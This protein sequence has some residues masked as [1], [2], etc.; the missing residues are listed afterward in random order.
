MTKRPSTPKKI[1]L[2][3]FED[4]TILASRIFASCNDVPPKFWKAIEIVDDYYEALGVYVIGNLDSVPRLGIEETPQG[5]KLV[6]LKNRV[7]EWQEAVEQIWPEF[8]KC[9]EGFIQPELNT[10][11]HVSFFHWGRFVSYPGRGR[12][13]V[14]KHRRCVI[15]KLDK[16]R[17]DLKDKGVNLKAKE[18]WRE[19][20]LAP[21]SG[22]DERQKRN[23]ITIKI[24]K[25][26]VGLTQTEA[27]CLMALQKELKNKTEYIRPVHITMQVWPGETSKG[28]NRLKYYWFNLRKKLKTKEYTL[29][30]FEHFP[31]KYEGYCLGTKDTPY[32]PP[33]WFKKIRFP[34]DL[35]LPPE[36]RPNR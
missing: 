8:E 17:Y 22:G 35:R 13:S 1:P 21:R 15:E 27:L 16:I 29:P 33:V 31:S 5:L 3:A 23:I 32:K 34:K 9:Y 20:P 10:T 30:G 36:V 12:A 26:D 2:E 19:N 18:L 14:I 6:S 7:T 28:K 24:E 11:Q 4:S 25:T